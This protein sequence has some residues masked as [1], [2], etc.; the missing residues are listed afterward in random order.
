MFSAE[1][2]NRWLGR[3]LAG[4]PVQITTEGGDLS[5][6]L[7]RGLSYVRR[8]RRARSLIELHIANRIGGHFDSSAVLGLR[9][10]LDMWCRR[11]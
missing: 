8:H 7:R 5:A 10:L 9:L 2:L 3:E 6:E 11:P 4:E 1:E